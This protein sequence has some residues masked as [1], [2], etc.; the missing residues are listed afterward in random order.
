MGKTQNLPEVRGPSSLIEMA[1]SK[2]ADEKALEKLEKVLE[3]QERW[4]ANEA[5]KAYH[6]AMSAFKLNPPDI[7]R[8]K[9]VSYTPQG[10]PTVTYN[11]ATLANVTSKI[12]AALSEHGLSATW[13]TK[14][15]NGNI[16]V[17]CKITHSMGHSEET[18]I[19]A[20]PDTSGSKNPIQAIGSTISYLERYTILAL[21]GLATHDMDDDGKGTD[22]EYIN[23]EQKKALV[24]EVSKRKIDVKK[25]NDHLKVKS[26]DELPAKRFNEAM[27]AAQSKPMPAAQGAMI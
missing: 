13:L 6:Q 26:I 22:I 1:L 5:K 8:D 17:T 16:S 11:H 25:F 14:Q 2:G 23:E 4:E 7:E 3:L 21:T 24:N 10:K 9:T 27:K 15:E 20:S 12:N 19:T 18:T